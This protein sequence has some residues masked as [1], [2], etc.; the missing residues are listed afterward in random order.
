MQVQKDLN[1]LVIAHRYDAFIKELVDVTSRYVARVDVLIH[2]NPLSEISNY[3]SGILYF[4]HLKRF[5]K[6]NLVNTKRRPPNVRVHLIPVI[7]LLPDGRN[8]EL[9][10]KLAKK[11]EEYIVKNKIQFD[12]IHAHFTYPQGYAAVKLGQKF[13]VPVIITLH[14]NGPHLNSILSNLKDKA[15]YTWKNAD[16]LVRVTKRDIPLFIQYGAD[17]SK[18]INIPNGYNPEKYYLI[19]S[20]TAR[21]KLQLEKNAKIIFNLARLY[22]EK[23][24]KYLIDAMSLVLKKRQDVYC[25]VG[26]TGPLKGE[27]EKKINKQNLGDHIRLL[28][29][30]P[31]D[32][33]NYWMNAADIFV[34]PSLSEGNPTVMFEALGV[35]LPFVGTA[36]GGVPEIITSEDYG[37]LCPP[38]DP[39]CLAKKILIALEKEWDREKI[40]TYAEQFK[41]QHISK[42][43][44]ELYYKV[45]TQYGGW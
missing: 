33:V 28:G 6:Q 18:I 40:R 27:L 26:G 36:V 32:Q 2:Y 37:L 24:H 3:F 11:F 12:I 29:Y 19:P 20:E 1:V 5:T 30:V 22:P 23:G 9:G 42:K 4:E 13:N 38:A 43:Y 17:P 41:W 10:D 16:K 25:Y 31:G 21:E 15:I 7:Y 14:E 45:L 44:V 39:E 35:G 34:L 8:K